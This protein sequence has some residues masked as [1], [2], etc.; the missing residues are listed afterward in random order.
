MRVLADLDQ[1]DVALAVDL[2]AGEEEH[3]DAALAGAVEQFAR[4]VGPESVLAAAQQRH[5]RPPVSAFARQQRGGRRDRRGIADR[6]MA[7]VADQ[8]RDHVGE[9]FF[10]AE[11][12]RRGVHTHTC[13]RYSAKPSGVAAIFAYSARCSASAA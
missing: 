5:V 12:K 8:P 9:Q 11:V 4:A 2:S 3:V 10:G 6:D 1:I 7:H 13:S